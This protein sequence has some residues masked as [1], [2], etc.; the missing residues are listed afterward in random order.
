MLIMR[1]FQSIQD[2]IGGVGCHN[3]AQFLIPVST[4]MPSLRFGKWESAVKLSNGC[5]FNLF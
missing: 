2:M 3:I 5:N 4:E 1:Q